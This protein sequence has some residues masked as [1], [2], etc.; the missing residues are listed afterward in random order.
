METGEEWLNVASPLQS[1]DHLRGRVLLVDFFTY[2]C[3]NCMHIL[4]HLH[5][6]EQNMSHAELLIIGV[7]SAK[8]DNEKV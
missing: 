3:I 5:K 6:L 4:P 7:H 2:C 8:F 1:E